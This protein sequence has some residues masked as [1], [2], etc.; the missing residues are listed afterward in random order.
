ML[1][2]VI[3]EQLKEKQL[4]LLSCWSITLLY[5]LVHLARVSC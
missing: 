1:I 4:P 3:A 2:A 5:L